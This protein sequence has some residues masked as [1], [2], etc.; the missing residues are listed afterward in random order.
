MEVNKGIK[1]DKF[2]EFIMKV[3][4]E[5]FGCKNLL[6]DFKFM[7]IVVKVAMAVWEIAEEKK[8]CIFHRTSSLLCIQILVHMY[9][10]MGIGWILCEWEIEQYKDKNS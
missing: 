7:K 8:L 6:Q 9:I 3:D 1:S 4:V 5:H 10:F 2:D